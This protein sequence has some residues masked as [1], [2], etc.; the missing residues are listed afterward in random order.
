MR[1]GMSAHRISAGQAADERRLYLFLLLVLLAGLSIGMVK[2]AT[3]LFA[4]SLGASKAEIGFITGSQPLMMAL[5]S[6][7]I[8]I[9]IGYVGA[10]GM[11]MLGSILAGAVYFLTPFA[12]SPYWLLLASAAA[13]M[14][15]P[16]RFISTQSE[17]FHYLAIAGQRKAGWLRGVQLAGAFVAGPMLG[18]YL[19][20]FLDYQ[21][22]FWLIGASFLATMGLAWG[23][24]SGRSEALGRRAED[25]PVPLRKALADLFSHRDIVETSL[26]DLVAHGSLMFYTVFI[27]LIALEQF[28]ASR[29]EAARLIALQG[30]SFMAALFLLNGLLARIGQ[31]RFYRLSFGVAVLGLGCLGMAQELAHLQLG[32]VLLGLGL[33]MLGIVNVVR[34][35]SVS[36]TLGRGTVA[37][38]SALSGPLGALAGTAGG[39]YASHWISL[40][41]QFLGLMTAMT[42]IA[43]LT[44]SRDSRGFLP[45]VLGASFAGVFKL[46][47]LLLFPVALAALWH[48]SALYGWTS[49]QILPPPAV[50]WATL[51]DLI[52]SG[53]VSTNLWISLKRVFAGFALGGGVGLALGFA[54]GLSR[55]ADAYL[56]PIFKA[57]ASV[58]MLGWIPLLIVL[59]GIEEALKVAVIAI[60]CVVP[61]ALNTLEG[62]KG[63][64][65]GYVEVARVFRFSPLQLLRK[66]IFP[67]AIPPIFAGISLSLSHAWKAMVAVELMASSEGIGF[68]MV[69]G[70][71]LFQLDVVLATILV[72]GAVGLVLDQLLRLAERSMTRWQPATA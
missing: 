3:P 57:L 4:L 35:A 64:P 19:L 24:L 13:S 45:R 69:M 18:S 32:G 54:M 11:F 34:L 22:A 38:A 70:R 53:E 48:A 25:R 50:V 20:G 27:V 43:S 66:V 67:A 49:Q 52:A 17:F 44:L 47:V 56:G 6:L 31:E 8:G 65:R 37:G 26:I 68:L 55:R 51:T 46:A 41:H 23:I 7:P 60:G 62:V 61:V 42:I 39:G 33:G 15:M 12:D 2:V 58:P 59:L 1:H 30:F 10:R 5:V 14:F 40:Q 9:A 29:D 72:I 21:G 36:E 28:H 63:V 71:Q 16:M